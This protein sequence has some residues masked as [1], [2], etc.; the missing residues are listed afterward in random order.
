MNRAAVLER[1]IRFWTW[2]FI[3]G[4]VFS[5][6]TAIPLPAEVECLARITGAQ[7]L[8]ARPGPSPAPAWATWLIQVQSA[9]G[10]MRERYPFIFYGGDWLAFGHFVI[11][12]FFIGAVR[13]PVRNR[14]L[15]DA[16]IIACLLVVP[17]AFLFGGFRGIPG[18]WRLIDCAFGVG[19]L[20]LLIPCKRWAGQLELMLRSGS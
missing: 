11:A 15:F 5:G 12:I 1:R 2:V 9:L 14:W 16:G 8:V 7:D 10:E 6:A 4:L 3:L 18:W 20:L 17:Y 19:G 13:D